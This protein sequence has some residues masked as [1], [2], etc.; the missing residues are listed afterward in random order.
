VRDV[1]L[2]MEAAED[3]ARMHNNNKKVDDD[4]EVDEDGEISVGCPSPAALP[5]HSDDEESHHSD[6]SYRRSVSSS[7]NVTRDE[8]DYFKPLKKLQ[9]VDKASEVRRRR[10]TPS[11]TTPTEEAPSA[12]EPAGAAAPSG[13]QPGVKSF[14]IMDILNHRPATPAAP[15]PLPL[16]RM[17][18]AAAFMLH[19]PMLA[20]ASRIVR[21]WD[22]GA[23]MLEPALMM[24]R[25]HQQ[26]QSLRRLQQQHQAAAA[27]AA[28]VA[29]AQ[30]QLQ[31]SR[32]QSADLSS[33]CSSGRSSTASDCCSPSP[34]LRRSQQRGQGAGGTASGQA[35][36]KGNDSSPLD[37]LFQM[38]S[39]TFEGLNG[40]QSAGQHAPILTPAKPIIAHSLGLHFYLLGSYVIQPF[41]TSQ[42]K[43]NNDKQLR[44]LG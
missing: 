14:S 12:A 42:V 29:A 27:A 21:P 30:H 1:V 32:P 3:F 20:A 10:R 19:N 11:P 7:P 24:E 36:A 34:D 8:E 37:A 35:S 23:A 16:R 26:N 38:T 6:S 40:E 44:R 17:D 22:L 31:V 25:L 43:D 2:N 9:M 39:K 5:T 13:A 28:A 18:T 41:T 33:A 4:M 15:L